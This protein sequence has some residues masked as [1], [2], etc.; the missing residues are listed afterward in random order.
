MLF[1]GYA[2]SFSLIAVSLFSESLLPRPTANA[3][4]APEVSLFRPPSP[5]SSK[6]VFCL[7]LFNQEF[8]VSLPPLR[9]V[10]SSFLDLFSLLEVILDVYIVLSVFSFDVVVE[11]CVSGLVNGRRVMRSSA[12]TFAS[13][14]DRSDFRRII[15]LPQRSFRSMEGYFSSF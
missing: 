8:Q 11:F 10:S 13:S 9:L 3:E 12:T 5:P 2:L 1:H 14:L 4:S 6:K 15:Y 7:Y